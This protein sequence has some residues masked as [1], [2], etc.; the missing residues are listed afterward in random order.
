MKVSSKMNKSID[1]TLYGR[2][3]GT[4][5]ELVQLCEHHRSVVKM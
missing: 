4:C 2:F 5:H 3:S 1:K